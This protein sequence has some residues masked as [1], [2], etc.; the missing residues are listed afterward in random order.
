MRHT[1]TRSY[2]AYLNTDMTFLYDRRGA[3]CNLLSIV[4][5]NIYQKHVLFYSMEC[6][7]IARDTRSND[8]AFRF[9]S[10]CQKLAHTIML[11]S[12]YHILRSHTNTHN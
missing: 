5:R 11:A 2:I 4:L 3:K 1:K 9:S 10:I 12:H 7:D 6:L 8:S